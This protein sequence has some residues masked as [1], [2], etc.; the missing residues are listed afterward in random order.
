MKTEYFKIEKKHQVKK[1]CELCNKTFKFQSRLKDHI[2]IHHLGQ[3]FECPQCDVTFTTK[4]VRDKHIL[5]IH[6]G[7]KILCPQCG[8]A[9]VDEPG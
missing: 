2:T 4:Q 3:R 8:S 7:Q 6:M 5:S 1:M 9:S